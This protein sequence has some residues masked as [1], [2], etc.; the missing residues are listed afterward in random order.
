M[1]LRG[2]G[3]AVS[4]SDAELRKRLNDEA[5]ARYGPKP[6]LPQWVGAVS[7][8]LLRGLLDLTER[9][10]ALEE[11]AHA[12]RWRREVATVEGE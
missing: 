5:A 11:T 6:T 2:R 7:L 12:E 4:H 8:M 3:H 1:R 9:V 10:E